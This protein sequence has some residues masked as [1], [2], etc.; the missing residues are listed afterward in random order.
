MQSSPGADKYGKRSKSTQKKEI[1]LRK[2]VIEQ[3]MDK[4]EAIK[5]IIAGY[6]KIAKMTLLEINAK[7]NNSSDNNFPDFF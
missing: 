1:E 7:A 3:S 2:Y 4:R 5:E 6:P